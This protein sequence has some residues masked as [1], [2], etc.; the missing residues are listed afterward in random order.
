MAVVAARAGVSKATVSR[1]INGKDGI[2]EYTAARVRAVIRELGYVPSSHAVGLARGRTHTI[3]IL[4]PSLTWPWVGEVLQGV[5]DVAES[6]GY[7]LLLFTFNR[8]AE[9]V[10]QFAAQ[11]SGKA[12][13][14]LLVIEPEGTMGYIEE[15]H[16][17]GLPV[18]LIDDRGHE[19]RVPWVGTTNRKG[20][21]DA[22]DHLIGL[23]RRRPLV[24]TGTPRFGC[25]RERVAG[26]AEGYAEA[27]SSLDPTLILEGDF[28]HA[29]GRAATLRALSASLE[30]DAVFAH[31]DVMA[32]AAIGVL[33]D[34]GR[35]IPD[36]VAVVG[37]DDLSLTTR[38]EPPL[39]AVRQP[40]REMGEAAAR[41]LLRRL[42]P[43]PPGDDPI[44]IPTTLTVRASTV[45]AKDPES[46]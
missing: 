28:T 34:A 44:V 2:D 35:R 22:A 11:L 6:E 27:G 45:G 38:T 14:G 20:A 42:G 4:I 15:L 1:V 43:N 30:F 31:N 18:V 5:A 29:G 9:S 32:G 21:R 46:R 36:D 3:G 39:T 8:G 13:D 25:T 19:P 7:G 24:I 40:V 23:G 26:F 17:R 16:D 12:F 33:R 41:A 10:R 37:F